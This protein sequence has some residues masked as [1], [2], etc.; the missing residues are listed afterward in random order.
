ME[1][2]SNVRKIAFLSD[3]VPRR[4]G[5][6]T[7]TADLRQ[8]I[9]SEYPSFESSIVAL[10]DRAEG[11]DYP[12]EVR[13]EIPEQDISAYRRAADFLNLAN[14][15]VLCL[16]HEFGIYGGPN[17][18]HLLTLLRKLRMPIVATLHTI[19][20]GPTP[21][22]KRTLQ[23]VIS[24]STRVVAMAEKGVE[25][26][27]D[28]YETP[29]EKID[30]IP[31]GIPD[32]PFIDPNF[33]KDKFGVEGRPVVLTFGL[34]SPNKGI[35]NVLNALPAVVREF[36]D[37]VY[38]V[39]GATH[40][41]LLLSQ[42]ETYRLGLERLAKKNGLEKNVI[43]FNRFV[44][45][46]ELVEFLGAADIYVTPYLEKS[47]ITS[48]TLTYSF[49]TG[50]AVISTPYWHAEELLAEDRGI[51]VP[52]GDS[53]AI[54]GALCD[55]LRNETKR[56]SMRKAAYSMGRQMVWPRVAHDYVG[57]FQR[58]R[59]EQSGLAVKRIVPATLD[60]EA[61][62]PIWRLDHLMRLTDDTGMLQHAVYT[63]PNYEH[64]YCTD[65]NARALI[66]TMLLE[67][68]EE[69][70]QDRARLSSVY[71]A[72]LQNA[73]DASNGRFRNFMLFNREWV[74]AIGS[75]D[76]HG[77]A[78]WA[79]GTCVGRSQR[80]GYRSWAAELFEKALPAVWDFVSPRA[81]AFAIIGL[82]EYLRTLSGDLM[83]NHFRSELA[84]RLKAYYDKAASPE[85]LWFEDV[86]TYDNARLPFA[87]IMTGRWAGQPELFEIGLKTL[88]WLAENQIA[89]EGHFRPIGSNGF[90]KRGEK[91]AAFDQ[92]PIE[93][94]AMISAC[95]EAYA[96]TGESRWLARAYKAFEWF[97]GG[98]DLGVA[99]YDAQSGGCRDG[100]HIDRAN[101]N[102][103]AE[104]TLAFLLSLAEMRRA[105]ITI[106]ALEEEAAIAS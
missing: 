58:A 51:L 99:L 102:Q 75:E 1:M 31:H 60:R 41:N 9:A 53:A 64:G 45:N 7:F 79:L 73:F 55:L 50:K 65:D 11:Y 18:R 19:L 93:A 47:Q 14:V 62:L 32:V 78:L 103:G 86:V 39:L 70:V 68:L 77:R 27:R 76:S 46:D 42:G 90:W 25:F 105:Q 101:Q 49:G 21:E 67:E 17:G 72:F 5:I 34:L 106:A 12:P 10:T 20:H 74:P 23:E 94:H 83:A 92:Q 80:E 97:H 33:Y 6:A 35:E 43:F 2:P 98:N 63:L 91:P 30:T 61:A 96:A 84:M 66:L 29:A 71:A 59:A 48:G 56:H 40:P 16:Q 54:A 22:Q 38:I 104:S 26:L 44:D 24:L 13:F 36:P 69:C 57:S 15:D 87:L 85:W 28:V 81:W 100:L 8:A 52:F 82:H 95:L 88:N 89:P 37:I 4:C 3:Y